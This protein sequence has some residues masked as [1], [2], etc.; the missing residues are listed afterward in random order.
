MARHCT[1]KCAGGTEA[2]PPPLAAPS[3]TPEELINV[4]KKK[5]RS[6]SPYFTESD[7]QQVRAAPLAAGHL[8][9]RTSI[10]WLQRTEYFVS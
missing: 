1:H 4:H 8:E 10:G 5:N 3:D 9:G 2:K 6:F 7:A